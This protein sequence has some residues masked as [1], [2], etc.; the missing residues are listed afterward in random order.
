[1]RFA[2]VDKN[3]TNKGDYKMEDMKITTGKVYDAMMQAEKLRERFENAMQ[4]INADRDLS[5]EGKEKKIAVIRTDYKKKNNDLKA[6][7]INAVEEIKGVIAST[8]YEY[9][10]DLEH[11][12]DY[13]KTMADAGI[14]TDAMFTHEMDKYRGSEMS[15]VFA[16]EKLKGSI[17]IDRFNDYTFSTYGDYDVNGERSFVSPLEHFNKLEEYIKSDND[18]MT[19]HMMEQTENKLG[20]ESVGRQNYN[21]EQKA[22]LQTMTANTSRLI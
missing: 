17:P 16:R 13:I 12:I 10:A 11:S 7:M 5:E 1:M 20:V 4:D 18:I 2:N 9:S 6:L 22:K 15:Y 19:A 21:A 3:I 14:L 8:P